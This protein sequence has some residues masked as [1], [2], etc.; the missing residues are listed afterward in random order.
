MW[1][2]ER[3]GDSHR[4]W[5]RY[6]GLCSGES[7]IF[8]L[9]SFF[10]PGMIWEMPM[11]ITQWFKK[12]ARYSNSEGQLANSL[13]ADSWINRTSRKRVIYYTE[14]KIVIIQHLFI[15]LLQNEWIHI[16]WIAP[17]IILL[18]SSSLTWGVGFWLERQAHCL[19]YEVLCH[20]RSRIILLPKSFWLLKFVNSS[21]YTPTKTWT[22]VKIYI[23]YPCIFIY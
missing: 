14:L 3:P 12:I 20:F 6:S 5:D 9:I 15:F 23:L 7:W 22:K 18:H 10:F 21:S 4:I 13:P 11:A 16:P 1:T 2:Q 17:C 19:T 8:S